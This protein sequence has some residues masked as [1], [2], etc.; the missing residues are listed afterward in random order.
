MALKENNIKTNTITK[1]NKLDFNS[2]TE[3]A[4]PNGSVV[5][6]VKTDKDTSTSPT[7]SSNTKATV[8]K[9]AAAPMGKPSVPGVD[10]L[11]V[12]PAGLEETYVS[13]NIDS[14]VLPTTSYDTISKNNITSTDKKFGIFDKKLT[15][16]NKT[17]F[18]KNNKSYRNNNKKLINK[19]NPPCAEE[20]NVLDN[21][22][23]TIT[24]VD[25]NANVAKVAVN[26]NLDKFI[27]NKLTSNI[28]SNLIG[29]DK[30]ISSIGTTG[31]LL[32]NN[33]IKNSTSGIMSVDLKSK[34]LNTITGCGPG[35]FD[36]L[37]GLDFGFNADL[38]KNLF[39][40]TDCGSPDSALVLAKSLVENGGDP[41][42]VL[43]GLVGS[44]VNSKYNTKG[45]LDAKTFSLDNNVSTAVNISKEG[46]IL[47]SIA[48]SKDKLNSTETISSLDTI[49]PTWNKDKH[50]NVSY[51]KVKNNKALIDS[52]AKEMATKI[53]EYNNNA[54]YSTSINDIQGMV[55]ASA[56][57]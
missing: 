37:L 52:G 2:V 5:T 38:F 22:I 24:K 32:K 21:A 15:D 31:K 57:A 19:T 49:V 47:S 50:G 18:L 26:T 30:A 56:F 29:K 10:L 34:L 54:T 44:S 48:N 25:T 1:L 36:N 20:T 23:T 33:L 12:V 55:I 53:P 43:A 39:G 13:S 28:G 3:I 40:N 7:S 46:S 42:A 27:N 17:D 16:C 41:K 8:S 51:Y 45:L 14:A 9:P 35:L 6:K 11:P 4:D